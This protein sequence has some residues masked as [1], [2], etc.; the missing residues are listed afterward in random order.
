MEYL[1]ADPMTTM[2]NFQGYSPTNSLFERDFSYR[3]SAVFNS[4]YSATKGQKASYKSR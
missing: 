1:V 4:F 2:S 3:R